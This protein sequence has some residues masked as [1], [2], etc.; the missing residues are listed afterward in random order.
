MPAGGAPGGGPDALVITDREFRHF[1][2]LVY[3]QTGIALG[4]QKRDLVRSR[5]GK[6]LREHG[7]ATFSQYA[8]HLAERDPEGWELG[9]MINAITTTKTEF[10]REEHHF[11]FLRSEVLARVAA[12][13]DVPRRLRIWSAGCS[14]GGEA[15]S[16]AI[17]VLDGIPDAWAWDVRILASDINTDTLAKGEA[18]VYP[19]EQIARLPRVMRAK[20]FA[21]CM[22]AK[23]GSVSVRPAVKALV[24][25]R[26]INLIDSGW[27]I[28]TPLD[29]IFC[30]N[31]LIYFDRSLQQRCVARL[32]EMLRPGGYLVLGGS[33]SLL[34]MNQGLEI[35]RNS[36]YRKADR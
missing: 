8:E 32:V 2:S 18:G 36:V 13:R 15:Y 11:A 7:Y 35:L 17:T 25:F 12:K 26:R 34:A 23:D 3:R 27:P 6:R 21:R 1:Q 16:I 29:C 30:R 33:E 31:V 24:T 14:S 22:G 10:F 4:E 9:R 19:A 20:Y 28:R 5:L